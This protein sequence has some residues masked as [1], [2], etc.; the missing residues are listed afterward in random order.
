MD[1]SRFGLFGSKKQAR[2]KEGESLLDPHD[3]VALKGR[4]AKGDDRAVRLAWKWLCGDCSSG[5]SEHLRQVA[6]LW[7]EYLWANRG[8]EE[9][10]EVFERA[11]QLE[12]E[13]NARRFEFFFRAADCHLELGRRADAEVRALKPLEM[14]LQN[15]ARDWIS[16]DALARLAHY[17]S[18]YAREAALRVMALE[19]WHAVP[20]SEADKG[21]AQR[22]LEIAFAFY[23]AGQISQATHFWRLVAA[24]APEATQ[25][26]LALR[27]L[28][29]CVLVRDGE[30]AAEPL[31]SELAGV[32]LKPLLER[33]LWKVRAIIAVGNGD[34]ARAREVFGVVESKGGFDSTLFNIENEMLVQSG[35][36]AT[37]RRAAHMMRDTATGTWTERNRVHILVALTSA[38]TEMRALLCEKPHFLPDA[39]KQLVIASR[40]AH[41]D[42]KLSFHVAAHKA[43][44]QAALGES[45]AAIESL[46]KL[47]PQ[48]ARWEDDRS[49]Q[50]SFCTSAGTAFLLLHKPDD[51]I[52]WLD[53]HLNLSHSPVHRLFAQELLARAHEMRG[54]TQTAT[55]LR[56]QVV[57]SGLKTT[58]VTLAKSCLGLE[59]EPQPQA[60]SPT[61][62][63]LL[64]QRAALENASD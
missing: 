2:S 8:F 20:V 63:P 41:G 12:P 58:A 36:F 16:L 54:D 62:V 64:W 49:T 51:A 44:I 61:K 11:A 28:A 15:P 22:H 14:H 52:H 57:A 38:S 21:R 27:S 45:D 31:L 39:A 30:A 10:A 7:G 48:W 29:G 34:F 47:T 50:L 56:E 43:A 33:E 24:D 19:A 6:R 25:Q 5:Q 46:D 13:T 55:A 3:L 17:R 60:A 1:L 42:D 35:D 4:L 23:W 26:T 9:A 18:R 53:E 59:D 37:A 40:R 32:A